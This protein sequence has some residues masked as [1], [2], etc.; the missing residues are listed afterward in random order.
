[1]KYPLFQPRT[2]ERKG[3]KEDVLEKCSSVSLIY[4]FQ[5]DPAIDLFS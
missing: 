4:M 1:M 3:K 5:S 2:Q